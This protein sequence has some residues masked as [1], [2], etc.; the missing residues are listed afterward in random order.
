[1]PERFKRCC[2]SL[3]PPPTNNN[4]NNRISVALV[5]WRH[6]THLRQIENY[7]I[8]FPFSLDF[9]LPE[10]REIFKKIFGN[11]GK[12]LRSRKFSGIEKLPKN[13]LGNF[14]ELDYL[15]ENF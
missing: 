9:Q 6:K 7:R 12:I 4:N 8:G 10:K 11:L 1:M 5:H 2:S 13:F 14:P 15:R 3:A